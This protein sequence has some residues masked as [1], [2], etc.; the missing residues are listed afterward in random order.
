MAGKP[1]TRKGGKR[2]DAKYKELLAKCK[3]ED[4]AVEING[5]V[6]LPDGTTHVTDSYD[7]GVVL[8]PTPAQRAKYAAAAKK[9]AAAAKKK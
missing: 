1:A 8:G 9:H 4:R 7:T 2:V 6:Y 3:K 5:I